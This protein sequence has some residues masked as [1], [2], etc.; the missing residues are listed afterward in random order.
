MCLNLED[1]SIL[2]EFFRAYEAEKNRTV[3]VLLGKID[4][5]EEEHNILS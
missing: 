5:F 3:W 1:T 2:I 4:Y